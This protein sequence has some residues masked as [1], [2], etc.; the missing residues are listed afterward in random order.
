MNEDQS[1]QTQPLTVSPNEVQ[2]KTI[3]LAYRNMNEAQKYLGEVI[4]QTRIALGL[5]D[6]YLFDPSRSSFVKQQPQPVAPSPKDVR[7]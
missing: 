1:K 2:L 6:S 5:D 4:V 3:E 7:H